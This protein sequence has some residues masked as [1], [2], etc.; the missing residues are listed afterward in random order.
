MFKFTLAKMYVIILCFVLVVSVSS[1]PSTCTCKWKG[2]KQWMECRDKFLITIPE[3]SD[4]ELTQVLDMSGNNLQIL[5]KEAFRRAG[6]LNLQKLFLARCHIGQIDAGALDGL[7]NIIEIDLSDNLLV[8]IPSSTFKSVRFLRDLNLARN[9]IQKIEKG[10]FQHVPG[11]VKLDLSESRLE[12][13]SPEAFT[14]AKSLESIKLNGNRLSHFPVRSVEPLNKLMM[15]ELHDNPWVCDCN[16]RSIKIWLTE[17]NKA[18]VQPACAGPERLSGRVFSDL[19]GD[20]FACKPEIRMDSR[21]VEAVSSENATVVCRV[22]SIPPASISWYWNG[23]LLINNTAFSSYQRIFV[24]EQGEYERKSSLILTNAQESDSGRFYCVAENRAGISDSNFTLQVNY[25][26]VGIPFLGGGHITGISLALFFLII[27]I[28][29]II[30]YLLIRMRTISYPSSSKNPAQIEVMANGNA[31]A[32]VNK[33]PSLTPVI[34]T[35]SFT[36]RKQFPPPSYHSTEMMSPNGQL[37]N[38]TLHSVI[39]ISNPDLINDTRKPE[40]LSPEPLN[41][42]VLFQ[43]NYWNQTIRQPTSSELGFDSNDKTPIIDG[44]SIGGDLEDNY[45]TDY[46]LPII[47]PGQNELLPNGSH[48]SAKTLRVWQRG[49]PVLPPVNALKRVLSRGSPDEGYQEGSGTDV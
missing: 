43:N 36:E 10:A 47:G 13:I 21:Y 11:L 17:N 5:P 1:C 44:V 35:S 37:P 27:I 48:P 46:G 25:R 30:I 12:H 19:H 31:H 2:G 20:D 23:R 28:L 41:D 8:S 45:P 38:K 34:E 22:D 15:I 42:D 14:G 24:V 32:V 39:N 7:T 40:G 26:G 9:P 29:I 33:T 18:P 6:L 3:S 4:S 16:M 49:V